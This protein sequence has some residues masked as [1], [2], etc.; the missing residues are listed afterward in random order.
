[1]RRLAACVEIDLLSTRYFNLRVSFPESTRAFCQRFDRL[2]CERL[3][4]SYSSHVLGSLDLV[5]DGCKKCVWRLLPARVA[6][7]SLDRSLANS[8][9]GLAKSSA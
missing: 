8:R 6:W 2:S 5:Q 4:R 1:V 9:V 3:A 7:S